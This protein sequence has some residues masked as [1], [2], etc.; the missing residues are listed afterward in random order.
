MGYPSIERPDPAMRAAIRDAVAKL[1]PDDRHYE[2]ALRTVAL[3]VYSDMGG[4]YLLREDGVVLGISIDP[5]FEPKEELSEMW[6]VIAR[7]EA[8]RAHPELAALLPVRTAEAVA[9][10]ACSGLGYFQFG[11]ARLGCGVCGSLGWCMPGHI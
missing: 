10:S 4:T 2:V 5:P 11:S 8:A 6:S 3:P 9:C 7:V 1:S